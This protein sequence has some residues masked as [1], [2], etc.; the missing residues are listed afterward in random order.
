MGLFDGI[1]C[2]NE[3]IRFFRSREYGPVRGGKEPFNIFRANNGN[4]PASKGIF[5]ALKWY[6][7]TP[8]DQISALVE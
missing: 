8:N 7:K 6:S 4:E 5:W 1:T 3:S 2:N